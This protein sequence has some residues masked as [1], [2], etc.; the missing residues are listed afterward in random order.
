MKFLDYHT[1]SSLP[2]EPTVIGQDFLRIVIGLLGLGLPFLLWGGLWLY[3]HEQHLPLPAIS[4]YYYTRISPVFVITLGTLALVLIAY[5]G[6]Q[7]IDFWLST[8]AGLFAL[9]VIIF[10]TNLAL[11]STTPRPSYYVTSIDDNCVRGALHFASAG[12]FLVCLAIISFFRFPKNESSDEVPSPLD[13]ALY[14]A[15]GIIMAVALLTVVLG[16][17]GV[18]LNK[19]W[20]IS[21]S[22]IYWYEAIAVWAFGYSWLLKAG[23][24]GKIA[25]KVRAARQ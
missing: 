12:I 23:F 18:I 19:K 24:F 17:M 11:E 2:E 3:S 13:K 8:T 14:R 10:P 20:F 21:H 5:R 22:G 16:S 25:R 6:K 4:N 9:F 1:D 7:P 15:C